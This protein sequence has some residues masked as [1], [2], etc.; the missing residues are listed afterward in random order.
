MENE[1]NS[2]H[3][4]MRIVTMFMIVFYHVIVHGKVI[5]NSVGSFNVLFY[6]TIYFFTMVHVNSFI[7]LTGYYQSTSKFK[8]S[9]IWKV[10]NANLFYK[11]M[12]LL[13]F[14][15]FGYITLDKFILVNQLFPF[16]TTENWYIKYYILILMISPFLNKA[17]SSFTKDDLKRLLLVSLFIFSICFISI[18][19]VLFFSF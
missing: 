7:L 4:L 8:Q 1:R 6:R 14:S 15:Y 10:I 5:E 2:N 12:I 19:C 16:E 13:I 3:E 9:K 11:L 17:L 18:T